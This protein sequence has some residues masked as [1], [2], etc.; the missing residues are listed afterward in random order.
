MIN[1]FRLL[2]QLELERVRLCLPGGKMVLDF[3]NVKSDDK[4]EP[5]QMLFK[6]QIEGII[7]MFWLHI[8]ERG[9]ILGDD[10]GM[11][12]TKQ[13][14]LFFLFCLIFFF[15]FRLGLLLMYFFRSVLS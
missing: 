1:F 4:D 7:W 15:L 9:G 12:K 2:G 11:G 6:H 14:R 5:P 8:I 3:R 13:V 10:M